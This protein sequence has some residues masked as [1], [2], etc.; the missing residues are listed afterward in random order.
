MDESRE[1]PQFHHRIGFDG[2]FVSVCMVCFVT[3]AEGEEESDLE[4]EEHGHTCDPEEVEC[5]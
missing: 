5:Y 4:A 1:F 2:T 3:V